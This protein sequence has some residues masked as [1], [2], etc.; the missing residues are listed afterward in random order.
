MKKSKFKPTL[1]AVAFLLAVIV[2]IMSLP[3]SAL[4]LGLGNDNQSLSDAIE[5][6]GEI[7]ELTDR[8]T[9]TTKTFR[10]EDGSCYLAQYDTAIH[11]LDADGVW[12]DIDNTLAANGSDIT[13]SDAKIKFA[14]KTT[15]NGN[16]FT[17][18]DGNKKLTLALDGAA[19]KIPGRITNHEGEYGTDATTLQKMTALDKFAASVKYEDIL[20]GTDLEYIVSGL[21]VKENII[22]KERQSSYSYSFTMSLNHL[23]ATLNEKG[24]IILSDPAS[25]EVFYWIPAPFMYDAGQNR[26]SA[27]SFALNDHGNGKYTLTVTADSGWLNAEERVFPVTIDPPIYTGANSSV[28]DIEVNTSSGTGADTPS[29]WVSSEWRAYWKLN[30]L[31]ALPAS[32]YVTDAQFTMTCFTSE[33]MYGYVAVYD[34]TSDWDAS[35]NWSK[36]TASENPQGVPATEFTDFQEIQCYEAEGLN[37]YWGYHW[38]ITPIVKKWYSGQNYGIMFGPATGTDFTGIA[39]F[40]ANEASDKTKR[41]QLCITYKDMKGLESYWSYTSQS[42]G[43]AGTGSVNNATGKLVFSIPTLTTIDSLMPFTPTFVYD[44]A[45]A[46]QEYYYPYAQMSYWGTYEPMSIKLNLNETL[47]KKSFT[48][49]EGNTAYFY[50]LSDS[51]GTEHYFM[52]TSESTV[53]EDEDGLLLKLEEGDLT[54]TITD[55]NNN[56]RTYHIFGWEPEGVVVGLYLIEIQD[57]NGNKVII[58]LD[59]ST[60]PTGISLKP[61]GRNPIEQL[62]FEYDGNG[63]PYLIWNPTSGEGV[64]VRYSATPTG[65]IAASSGKYLRQ[66]VR[67]HG[68]TTSAMWSSFYNTDSNSSSGGITVDAVA[69]YTYNSDGLITCVTNSLSRYKVEYG[70]DAAKRVTS[71]KEWAV[72]T[73]DTAGQQL[74]LTY[75]ASSTV[76]RTSGTDDIFNTDDDLLTTYGFDKEGRTV[77]CYTTDL[78]KTQIYGASNGQ[79]VGDDNPKA[80]NN[81]KSSVQTTQRSSNY[82]LNGGFEETASDSIPYWNKTGTA[83]CW[84]LMQHEGRACAALTVNATTTSSS[85]YQ[86]VSLDK[87]EYSLALYINTH[88]LP[89]GVHIYLK[90]ESMSNSAHSVTQEIAGNKYYATGHYAFAGLNFTADPGASGGKERFKISVVVTGSPSAD[91]VV[92]VDNVMLSRT[93]G[94]AE[95]DLVNAGHFE[96]SMDAVTP[97]SFWRILDY[98]SKPVTIVDSGIPAFGKVLKI[99]IDLD[100]YEFVEQTVYQTTDS[101][102]TEYIET[103]RGDGKDPIMFTVSGWGKGTAQ[104]YAVT[105]LFCIQATVQYYDGTD[106]PPEDTFYFD[107]DKGITDWQFISGGFAT[108]PDKGL[109]DSITITFMYSHHPGEGYF[110]NV[111]VVRD[112]NTTDIYDYDAKGYLTTHKNG[113]N[114]AWYQYDDN[115]NVIRAVSSN[116]SMVTYEYDSKNRVKKEYHKKYTGYFRPS[117]GEVV[118]G[119]VTEKFYYSYGYNSFGQPTYVWTYDSAENST[120][121]SFSVTEYNTQNGTH[122]FGSVANEIDSLWN[123]TRYFYDETNGRLLATA[124]PEGNGVCYQYD[125]IGNLT[126]VLPATLVETVTEYEDPDGISIRDYSYSYAPNSNSASVS[127]EYDPVTKRLSSITTG[128]TE[129]TFV[130]DAFGNTTGISAGDHSLAG[131]EYNNNNGKLNTLTY[132]NGLKVKYVYDILDRISEIRYNT[133]ENGAFETV[134]SYTYDS[135]GNI[136]SLT[137]HKANE[138]T[139]YK[140]DSESKLVQ[141]YVY[142]SE[143]YTNRYGSSIYYDEQ[144][145]ISMVFHNV[146]YSC[147]A[148]SYYGTT[149]YDSASYSYSYNDA[150]GNLR[151]L[152]YSGDLVYGVISPVYD[153]FGRVESKVIDF[154]V[155]DV[156]AFYNR[157]IYDYKT[158]DNYESGLVSKVISSVG[159]NSDL[160]TA[161]TRYYE[162]D[163]NGNITQIADGSGVIQ[164]KYYYDSL[165]QLVREDNRAKNCSYVY[166]YDNAGNITA[167]RWYAFTTGTL[168]TPQGVDLYS[169]EDSL[170]GDLLTY[171]GDDRIVYDE[172]GNPTMIGYYYEGD[173]YGGYVMTWKG[174]QM[175]SCMNVD[176]STMLNFTYN[177]DG[178]RTSK[179]VEGVEHRYTLSGS[180]IISESWEEGGVEHLLIYIYDENGSPIGLKYRTD[181]YAAERY[182]YFF[183]E[184]NL[185]GDII[186]IYNESGDQIGTYTY[187]AWGE[188]SSIFNKERTVLEFNI[189]FTMN[190]FRYRGYY[191]DVETGWYY[192]QSR[193]YNP[194]WGRFLNADGRLNGGILGYNQFAYCLNNPIM[195]CDHSG[196]CAHNNSRF[197]DCVECNS[198]AIEYAPYVPPEEPE[199]SSSVDW[200]A[201]YIEVLNTASD[202]VF[203]WG[204]TEVEIRMSR[205]ILN[206]PNST[207]HI[208]LK[209]APSVIN[210]YGIISDVMTGILFNVQRG[211]SMQQICTE[212]MI[213]LMISV[214]PSLIL[215]SIGLLPGGAAGIIIAVGIDLTFE[216]LMDCVTYPNGKTGRENF[217]SLYGY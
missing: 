170:W 88:E 157:L 199:S 91:E 210:A 87:G 105:S 171:W 172:I 46:N 44:S 216:I 177:A 67:A 49:Q 166:E 110:D 132:G 145:R 102:R 194:Q 96:S 97:G 117:D 81:L 137:D 116:K 124:Y 152:V 18:H 6:S 125:A 208:I 21:D 100:E 195:F 106:M 45:M 161:T 197:S 213:D 139:L 57:K 40:Y 127:Y 36:V 120:A 164:N 169:Y 192:L 92:W 28:L 65:E 202:N 131:Y 174:R 17:I 8:R 5:K 62:K 109:V 31:P 41:P 140:Y 76:I 144:S 84:S 108:N 15:G 86:Y 85:I 186:A 204:L 130:Y 182:N 38:N 183:F 214:G 32:A 103:G 75:G 26:S 184:K 149:Y 25:G 143:T 114:T 69:D 95:Y 122:I 51:D 70:Y 189:L 90:A 185:Q 175:M 167:K 37:D 112:S 205:M 82:L 54:S 119:T 155:D 14:K 111:S 78:D 165:G 191:Y 66:I 173:W 148:G 4:A 80:R 60:R 168:G 68:G 13:T 126:G 53:Y 16:I 209:N 163:D 9:E 147:P 187:T 61:N 142:D 35:L 121:Q 207:A 55:K 99:D 217:K 29:L 206:A 188:V 178:I 180:Q 190:P 200:E 211:A 138:V 198:G 150:T 56:V 7:F 2:V 52:P 12:Q 63:R 23:A 79:Y 201:I 47:I 123:I 74:S 83:T 176:L 48:N 34:V 3:L 212:G 154:E 73:P 1:K 113:R 160:T 193:Y 71:V 98:G 179:T 159:I 136:F 50:V 104:A 10:L 89:D 77:S 22:V 215:T 20:P 129:Y 181:S 146:D 162:Y 30:T 58:D 107:F 42:A 153:S 11:Y 135:A 27:V 156:E 94:A 101:R 43:F 158:S 59:T 203:C 128:S 39:K 93:T 19:K 33:Y 115:N 141:F 133:G 72:G 151:Y 64:V 134:Y 118:N 196:N 24:E